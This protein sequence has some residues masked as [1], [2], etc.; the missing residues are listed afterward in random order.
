MS[1]DA[2][3]ALWLNRLVG[4]NVREY[5]SIV[6]AWGSERAA[7]EAAA[8]KKPVAGDDD[9]LN[10]RMREA[11]REEKID[12]YSKWLRRHE[13]QTVTYLEETYPP[14]L[15]EI[16][17][18]PTVLFVKGRL[19]HPDQLTIAVVGARKNT[20]YGADTAK[21]LS[22]ELAR[23][24]CCVVSGLAYGIDACAATAA[25]LA[26]DN[27]C[28]TL[29]VLGCGVDVAYPAEN[30]DLYRAVIEKG[31][32]VSE[33]APGTTPLPHHFPKRNR[34]ISGLARGVL[35]VEA[36]EKSGTQI[37]VGHALE[38]GRDVFAVPG[39]ITDSRSVGT[40]RLLRDGHAK[41]VLGVGDILEEYGFDIAGGEAE[42]KEPDLSGLPDL[43]RRVVELVAVEPRSADELCQILAVE[44]K[45]L[46]STLTSL[47][48]SGIMKQLPG[49]V[50]SL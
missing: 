37:T 36:G 10:A 22:F 42:R 24:G 34:I 47:E 41:L 8:Q 2:R 46:N 44:V 21:A 7:F 28:P 45:E 49:R 29:A 20:R 50:Y 30:E 15:R 5:R 18:P 39:R 3:Y 25:L 17:D 19:P 40:N 1:E 27:P 48:F 23:Q 33:F 31:A 11:A 13:I 35:V 6:D 32:V 26:E 14:L 16:Y 9:A 43:A 12:K 4:D 38:Q